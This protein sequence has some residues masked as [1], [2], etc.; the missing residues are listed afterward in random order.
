MHNSNILTLALAATTTTTTASLLP[1]QPEANCTD[2]S[3]YECQQSQTNYLVSVCL[4]DNSTGFPDLNAP[5]NQVSAIT[6]QCVYGA[7]GL[8]V[9]TGDSSAYTSLDNEQDIPMLSNDTQRACVCESQF[10][11]ALQGCNDCYKAHGG[12]IDGSGPGTGA[13]D[14]VF[15]ASASSSYCAVSNTPTVGFADVLYGYA[16]GNFASAMATEMASVTSVF[17]DPAGNQTAVSVYF[18]PSVTGSGAWVVAQA[19]ETAGSNNGTTAASGSS[20]SGPSL[21]T[22]NGQIVATQAA[23]SSTAGR[24]GGGTASGSGAAAST[25]AGNGAGKQEAAALAGVLV[26]VGF[27]A[28]L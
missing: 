6:A 18:T 27:V 26:L 8:G 12:S 13:L 19:T 20:N 15:L 14:P 22:S 4:P 2:P 24:S 28:M 9:F 7:A 3:S 5:C 10:F 25:T 16:T 11:S 23:A 1:R 21:A 17:S